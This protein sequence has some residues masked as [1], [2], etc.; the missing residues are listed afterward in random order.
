MENR[1]ILNLSKIAIFLKK[2]NH[3][4]FLCEKSSPHRVMSFVYRYIGSVIFWYYETRK[5]KFK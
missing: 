1:N 2:K 4:Y 3:R 5:K